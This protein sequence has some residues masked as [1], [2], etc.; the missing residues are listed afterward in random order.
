MFEA[1]NV[2]INDGKCMKALNV[3]SRSRFIC[4]LFGKPC[5]LHDDLMTGRLSLNDQLT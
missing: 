3:V 4:V 2:Y 5:I 1:G